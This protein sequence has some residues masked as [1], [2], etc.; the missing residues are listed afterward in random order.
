MRSSAVYFREK[1]FGIERELCFA[2]HCRAHLLMTELIL[3]QQDT[4]LP[5][6]GHLR[7]PPAS[8]DSSRSLGDGVGNVHYQY[9]GSDNI[10]RMFWEGEKPGAPGPTDNIRKMPP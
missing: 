10:T 5:G 3:D 4:I 1:R 2:V 9:G 7:R 6:E 8:R